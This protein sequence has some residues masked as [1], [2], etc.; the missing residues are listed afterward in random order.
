MPCSDF[1]GR[2]LAGDIVAKTS[3]AVDQARLEGN[4]ADIGLSRHGHAR[5]AGFGGVGGGVAFFVPEPGDFGGAMTDFMPSDFDFAEAIGNFLAAR[6]QRGAG[7][8]RFH[9]EL[10]DQSC[11]DGVGLLQEPI[12]N[13]HDF[14]PIV[15]RRRRGVVDNQGA[16]Q[17]VAVVLHA[18]VGVVPVRAGRRGGE[19][20]GEF[21][22][23]RNRLVRNAVDAIHLPSARLMHAVPMDRCWDC[24]I[25]D[26]A[27]L[28]LLPE[29]GGVRPALGILPS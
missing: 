12:V 16:E 10:F 13:E 25:V 9:V 4:I 22:A 17:S 21:F 29:F 28:Q 26:D 3:L 5:H 8:H 1:D 19:F 2:Q 23:G 27:N 11:E 15:F 14:F 18:G 7:R 20:V 6:F 24:Q